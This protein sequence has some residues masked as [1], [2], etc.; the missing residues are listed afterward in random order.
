MDVTITIEWMDE[1]ELSTFLKKCSQRNN[2]HANYAVALF[3]GRTLNL[4]QSSAVAK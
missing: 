1:Y 2:R 4:C 3:V